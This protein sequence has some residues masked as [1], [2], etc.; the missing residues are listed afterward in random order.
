MRVW[1]RADW[2]ARPPKS[3]TPAEPP[4]VYA[5]VHHTVT[6][7]PDT[8][9]DAAQQCRSIQAFHQDVRGW[10]DI[11]YSWL[12][13]DGDV[14]EG[15]GWGVAQAAQV[16][17]NS[18][19]LSFAIIGDGSTAPASYADI[20]ATAQAIRSGIALG[21]MPTDVQIVAHRDLNPDTECCGDYIYDQLNLIRTL[22]YG[23]GPVTPTEQIVA[24]MYRLWALRP[25]DPEGIKYWA[26][27]LD[28][29]QADA[30]YVAFQMLFNEGW[31]RM[32]D[33]T[34]GRG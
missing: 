31:S 28:N 29:G 18:T 27:L 7:W 24:D 3:V 26:T 2:G 25:G 30:H 8:P 23:G 14:F 9:D 1:S 6:G 12:I 16:G 19:A 20:E 5:V 15:R 21:Q 33:R 32:V 17:Y 4:Q 34:G 11:G 22:V 10:A 13:G